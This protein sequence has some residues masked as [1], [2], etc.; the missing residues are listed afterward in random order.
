MNF[1]QLHTKKIEVNCC[2]KVEKNGCQI[3]FWS[4]GLDFVYNR[5][6]FMLFYRALAF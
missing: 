4:N 1:Q 5:A 3:K 2:L 6:C